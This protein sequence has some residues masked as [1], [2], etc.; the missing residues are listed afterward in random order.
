M[1]DMNGF[2]ATDEIRWLEGDQKHT[3]IVALTA[4]AIKG[5]REKCLA[6]G[7]DEYLSKPIRSVKLQEIVMRW[8][9]PL[10]KTSLRPL[11]P[12]SEEN[13]REAAS[14]FAFDVGRLRKLQKMFEKA[15]KD[16]VPAVVE[17]YFKNI[18]K[19]IPALYMAIEEKNFSEIYETAHFL[20]GGSRNLGL[21]KLSE[22][23]T[24]LQENATRD[25]HN[26]VRELVIS[27][28]RELP[29]TKAYMDSMRGNSPAD[30]EQD[31]GKLTEFPE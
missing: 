11:L 31:Y 14:D 10:R 22:I 15:G 29:L 21:L 2:E 27:L 30:N 13:W 17:P 1:P 25:D 9:T 5:F 16:F 20:L 4:N 7:M 12:H 8:A 24:A 23:C 19:Q 28:E 18:E 6:A 26:S 3:I